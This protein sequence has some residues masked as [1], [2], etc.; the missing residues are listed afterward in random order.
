ME[1][2]LILSGPPGAGKT[3]VALAIC[4]RFDRM[5]HVSVDDLRHWVRAGYRRP[6]ETGQQAREQLVMSAQ[7]AAALARVAVGHRYAAIIDDV[8]TRSQVDLY[9]Q[10]LLG[11]PAEVHLVTLLPR[12]DTCLARDATRGASAIPE[13][14]RA[15]HAELTLAIAEGAIPG[16]VLD[17][18]ADVDAY[19]TA[20]RVQDAVSRG[21]ARFT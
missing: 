20:D 12:L 17:S 18:T 16:A 21:V 10:A 11:I 9:R 8:V 7:N 4:E 14:V 2:V 1:Q 5:L 19:A 6:W 13:R 15:V 3:A